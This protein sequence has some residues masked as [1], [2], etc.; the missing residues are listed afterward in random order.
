MVSLWD[1]PYVYGPGHA[2][3]GSPYVYGLLVCVWATCMCIGQPIQVWAKYLYGMEHVQAVC[4]LCVGIK[5]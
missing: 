2:C 4:L 3:K 5:E 1:G